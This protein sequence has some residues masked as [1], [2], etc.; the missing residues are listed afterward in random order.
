MFFHLPC[1]KNPGITWCSHVSSGERVESCRSE[2]QGQFHHQA[3]ITAEVRI[4]SVTTH[5]GAAQ[6]NSKDPL[7]PGNA[8]Y[9]LDVQKVQRGMEQSGQGADPG[10]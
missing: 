9:A 3:V 8:L 7:T 2:L 1:C 4:I 6:S 10:S 5:F